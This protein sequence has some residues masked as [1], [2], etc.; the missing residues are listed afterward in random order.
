VCVY[1][2]DYRLAARERGEEANSGRLMKL[3]DTKKIL[4]RRSQF[5]K[6]NPSSNAASVGFR[7]SGVVNVS[8]SGAHQ[9]VQSRARS[10][11][12][13]S[14]GPITCFLPSS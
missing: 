2:P 6:I 4:E 14:G 10:M 3:L 8:E 13:E 7:D 5:L 9:S 11:K 1:L 12:D